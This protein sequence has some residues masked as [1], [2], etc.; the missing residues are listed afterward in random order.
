MNTKVAVIGSGAG[1]M[2]LIS[3]A[4]KKFAIDVYDKA[5]NTSRPLAGSLPLTSMLMFG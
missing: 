1:A 3:Q 5:S 4:P 2:G